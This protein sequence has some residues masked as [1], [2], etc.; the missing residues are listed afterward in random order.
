MILAMVEVEV[1]ASYSNVLKTVRIIT[2]KNPMANRACWDLLTETY[3]TSM[4]LVGELRWNERIWRFNNVQ[5]NGVIVSEWL[6]YA[7]Q[8]EHP[9]Y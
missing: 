3:M 9:K 1:V 5:K 6:E 4:V 8:A 2:T 7:Q